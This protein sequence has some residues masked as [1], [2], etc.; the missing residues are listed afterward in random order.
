M[1]R[2]SLATILTRRTV[3]RMADAGSL[4]R[5]ADYA[6]RGRVHG[7]AHD[8]EV[9]VA[10]VVG[11]R[12]YRVRLW[13]EDDA[14]AHACTCPV[15]E[16]GRFCKHCVAVGLAW[17]AARASAAPAAQPSLADVRAHLAGLSREALVELLMEQAAVDERLRRR[18]SLETTRR[19]I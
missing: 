12:R 8:G 19:D 15:G 14:L 10:E 4:E 7:L 6:A 1:G 17:I 16:D 11:G 5:G 13:A 18:L 3:H 9:V 2:Q